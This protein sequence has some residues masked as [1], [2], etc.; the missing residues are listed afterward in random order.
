MSQRKKPSIQFTSLHAHST[1]GSISDALAYPDEHFN[2]AYSNGLSGMALTEHGNLNSL[3]YSFLHSQKMKKDGKTDFRILYGIEAYIHPSIKSWVEDRERYNLDKKLSKEVETEQQVIAED[4]TETKK[5]IRNPLNKRGHLVLIAQNNVGLNNIYK[6]TSESYTGDNFYRYPRMDFD[7]LKKHNE[8]IIALQSCIG[9]IVALSY[10]E[11]KDNG[12]KAVLQAMEQTYGSLLDI[13]GDRFYGELQWAN[14]PDQHRINSLTIEL[15]KQLGFQVVSTVDSHYPSPDKWKDREIYKM[16]GWLNKKQDIDIAGL[17][18]TLDEMQYQLYPKNGDELY[19]SYKR[20]AKEQGYEYDDEFVL[21]SIERTTDIMNNRVEK[22]EIDTSIK[23]PSFVIPAGE[24]ADSALVKMALQG[25]KQKGLHTDQ[26]YVDRLKREIK[27]VQEKKFSQYFLMVKD[28]VDLAKDKML[29]GISRGSASGSLLAYCLGI[30]QIDSLKYKLPFER[31]LNNAG[32][33]PDIDL[34][35]QDN[36][37]MKNSIIEHFGKENTALISNFNTLQLKSLIKDIGKL[38]KIPFQEVNQVTTKMLEEATPLAKKKNGILAGVYDP[39]YEELKQFSPTFNKFLHDYPEVGK[40]ITNILDNVRNNSTHAAGMIICD[41]LSQKMPLMMRDGV[42]QTPWAEGQNVRHLEPMGFIKID[43]LG[44]NT[45]DLIYKCISKILK[46]QN[47][48]EPTFEEIKKFYQE[49]LSVE[50]IDFNDQKVYENVFHNSKWTGG[51]FQFTG[52]GVQKFCNDVKPR[53]IEELSAITSIYR[54]GPL[55]SNVD[56]QYLEAKN[57][58]DTVV[59]EHPIIEE[60]L[61]A[62]YGLFVYQEDISTIT[63]MLGKDIS[64]DE[65]QEFRKVLT[66]KGLGGKEIEVKERIKNKFIV[67]CTEKGLD[68]EKAHEIYKKMEYFAQYSFSKNHSLAYCM[69]SFHCAYLWTYYPN[70]WMAAYLDFES[71][72]EKENAIALAKSYGFKIKKLDINKSGTEWTIDEDDDKVLIQPLSSIKGLGDVAIAEIMQH[73]PFKDIE[74][75]LF[76]DNIKYNKLNKRSLDVLCRSEALNGLVDSRFSGT[77]HFWSVVAV[78]RPKNLKKFKE[79]IELYKPEGDFSDEEKIENITALSGV[80]PLN[81]IVN[82][83][84][85]SKLQSKNIEPLGAATNGTNSTFWWFIPRKRE[86]KTTKTGKPYWIIEV[87]D[88][89]NTLTEIKCWSIRETDVVHMNRLYMAQVS[90]DSYGYS[91]KNWKDH[92]RLLS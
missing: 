10:W 66:K 28:V 76:N 77:K 48:K 26:E 60:V 35:F 40:N 71:E 79:N 59:Y 84:M 55:S 92:V 36:K 22:F 11:N 47:K 30:T 46:R 31:F 69:T 42:Y 24:T 19:A 3:S 33:F 16:L 9:S 32:G 13:F 65:G 49:K 1:A 63:H 45:L 27:F 75:L 8:G 81:L 4:E 78:D 57:N 39:T 7:M 43:V 68:V 21:D 89:T 56:K 80:Y 82:D 73:R 87:T 86:I 91:I 52:T 54:P 34:D 53:N 50:N 88:N 5:G 72:D 23:L 70:E 85:L 29:Y 18:N 61:K 2:F 67:G 25:F 90:R 58:P 83:E 6:L 12:N 14:N 20:T 38:Y 44:L 17:P 51:I 64:P 41:N 62:N 74:S 15:S 37:A